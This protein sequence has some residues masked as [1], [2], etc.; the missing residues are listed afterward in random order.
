MRFRYLAVLQNKEEFK[1][2]EKVPHV[3]RGREA[4]PKALPITNVGT[5]VPKIS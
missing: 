2:K 4:N 1:K 3:S 5:I